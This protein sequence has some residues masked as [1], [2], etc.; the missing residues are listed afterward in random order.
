MLERNGPPEQH[1]QGV[2]S[3]AGEIRLLGVS[4]AKRCLITKTFWWG[5][6][7]WVDLPQA[8]WWPI[9]KNLPG[10]QGN[11]Q[12]LD[13]VNYL[14][15]H[16]SHIALQRQ[17]VE[18]RHCEVTR[19]GIVIVDHFHPPKWAHCFHVCI[20]GCCHNF[21]AESWSTGIQARHWCDGFEDH[22]QFWPSI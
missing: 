13:G 1:F 14:R 11:G 5:T 19:R 21:S 17:D 12:R 18:P 22:N 16:R 2:C 4:L 15:H 20:Y 10:T 3:S 7:R 6:S 9:F 8:G